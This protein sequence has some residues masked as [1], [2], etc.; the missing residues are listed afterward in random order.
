[1]RMHSKNI[2]FKCLKYFPITY[3]VLIY[4]AKIIDIKKN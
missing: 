4:L 3:T 1:M 2:F